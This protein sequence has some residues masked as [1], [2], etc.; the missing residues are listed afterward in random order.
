[1]GTRN[2]TDVG[3]VCRHHFIG[4][5]CLRS[6]TQRVGTKLLTHSYLCEWIFFAIWLIVCFSFDRKSTIDWR[7][8]YYSSK[9]LFW[10]TSVQFRTRSRSRHSNNEELIIPG[11]VYSRSSDSQHQSKSHIPTFWLILSLTHSLSHTSTLSVCCSV[12][13]SNFFWFG[14]FPNHI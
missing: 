2:A 5:S 6:K 7:N 8:G 4:Q 1:M 11:R 10:T 3:N 12:Q 13:E 14:W 9:K